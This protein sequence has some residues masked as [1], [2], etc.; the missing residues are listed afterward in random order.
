MV[1]GLGPQA[2]PGLLQTAEPYFITDLTP[3]QLLTFSVLAIKANLDE[4][5]NFVAAGSPGRAGAAS[6]VYLADSAYATF[7]DLKDG[8][9]G[10]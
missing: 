4:M 9:I 2:V 6:V 3:E 8:R 7:E 1:R 10:S 5:P